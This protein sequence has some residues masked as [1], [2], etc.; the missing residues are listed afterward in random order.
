MLIKL[1]VAMSHTYNGGEMLSHAISGQGSAKVGK[2]IFEAALWTL[3]HKPLSL[4]HL[5]STDKYT[6]LST[7]GKDKDLSDLPALLT[8][9]GD[10]KDGKDTFYIVNPST[11]SLTLYHV[12]LIY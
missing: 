11:P 9:P 2:Q 7:C 12:V 5:T 10:G 3:C 1:P 8:P 6:V 4:K